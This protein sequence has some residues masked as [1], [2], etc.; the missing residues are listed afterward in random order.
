MINYWF[1]LSEKIL[2][3]SIE[4]L[5]VTPQMLYAGLRETNKTTEHKLSYF[6]ND[7]TP[8]GNNYLE[9]LSRLI[10]LNG[11][12]PAPRYARMLGADPRQFDGAIR[13]LTGM[14]AHDW[15]NEYLRLIACDLLEHTSFTF[16]EVGRMLNMSQSSFSQF[17]QAHQHMQP[18]E[19]RSLKQRGKKAN[20]F[21]D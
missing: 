13:C 4:Y 6:V 19:Y 11:K 7:A 12:R 9:V 20:Y 21:Y 3:M 5:P 15:I 18:W 14:S 2:L 1:N 10:I 17:F 16:K 8:S